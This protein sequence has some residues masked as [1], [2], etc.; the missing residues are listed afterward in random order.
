MADISLTVQWT[1]GD[2]FSF[3][4]PVTGK[5]YNWRAVVDGETVIV[6]EA[7]EP[8]LLKL[9]YMYGCGC[10]GGHGN[11]ERRNYFVRAPAQS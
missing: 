3:V 2:I 4:G 5:R 9:S 11:N 7:D 10:T 8:E 1:G 6:D